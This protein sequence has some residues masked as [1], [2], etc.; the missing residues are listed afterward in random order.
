MK[1]RMDTLPF[2][3]TEEEYAQLEAVAEAKGTTISEVIREAIHKCVEDNKK[4]IGVC[5]S[6]LEKSI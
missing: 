4:F 1:Q 6:L 3:L 2:R 5:E